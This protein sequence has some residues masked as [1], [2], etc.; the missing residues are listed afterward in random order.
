MYQ[1]KTHDTSAILY[2]TNRR[3]IIRN[4]IFSHAFVMSRTIRRFDILFL[5][6]AAKRS[7]VITG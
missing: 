7:N 6:S 3:N 1:K 5:H 4:H 2:A